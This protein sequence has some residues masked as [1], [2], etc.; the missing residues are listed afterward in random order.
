MNSLNTTHCSIQYTQLLSL[1]LVFARYLNDILF[2]VF[3]YDRL[4]THDVKTASKQLATF[5]N[6]LFISGEQR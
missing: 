6:P 5:V 2:I 3:P 1:P 4:H